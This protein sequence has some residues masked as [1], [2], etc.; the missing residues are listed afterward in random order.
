MFDVLNAADIG[1]TLTENY[2]M[3]PA[4]SVSGFY[5][6]HPQAKYFNVGRIGRDQLEDLAVRK[7]E[8]VSELERWLAPN[9]G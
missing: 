3:H 1:M 4:S 5:L 8:A 2:A 6:A 9:L 7:R